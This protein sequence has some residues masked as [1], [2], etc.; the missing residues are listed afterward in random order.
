[1]AC[2][3]FLCSFLSLHPSFVFIVFLFS[4]LDFSSQPNPVLRTNSSCYFQSAIWFLMVVTFVYFPFIEFFQV[5]FETPMLCQDLSE[6]ILHFSM[7][8]SYHFLTSGFSFL[9]QD[10]FGV[11]FQKNCH[12]FCIVSFISF[13]VLFFLYI[14]ARSCARSSIGISP[15]I[16]FA[17]GLN[18]VLYASQIFIVNILYSKLVLATSLLLLSICL[19]FPPNCSAFVTPT[20]FLRSRASMISFHGTE[21]KGFW[22]SK[23][24]ATHYLLVCLIFI[25]AAYFIMVIFF[26]PVDVPCASASPLFCSVSVFR[27]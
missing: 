10:A 11:F 12:C 3:P 22:M 20:F 21:L 23:S 17:M 25:L 15:A 8:F 14:S 16:T 26:L 27:Q 7:F 1:M 5:C 19:F 6:V 24:T 2:G 4:V 18:T 9:V 13:F